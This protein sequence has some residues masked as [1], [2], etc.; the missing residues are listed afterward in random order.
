MDSFKKG[1]IITYDAPVDP[2]RYDYRYFRKST[3]TY[4]VGN[5][6]SRKRKLLQIN[7][8]IIEEVELYDYNRGEIILIEIGK[9][10]DG[11][12]SG[13]YQITGKEKKKFKL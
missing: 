10:R 1:D 7:S 9:L 5:K 2:F 4:Q 13:V 6:T 3:R 12:K 11:L 8:P